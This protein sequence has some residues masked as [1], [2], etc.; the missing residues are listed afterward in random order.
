MAND[1][2]WRQA[3][4]SVPE[5]ALRI[6]YRYWFIARAV[7]AQSVCKPIEGELAG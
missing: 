1:G 2:K 4:V 5:A 3:A 7:R 6:V